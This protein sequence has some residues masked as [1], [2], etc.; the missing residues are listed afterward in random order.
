M[1]MFSIDVC[2]KCETQLSNSQKMYSNGTCCFCGNTNS[3]TVT[4]T[5]KIVYKKIRINPI[6]KFWTQQFNTIKQ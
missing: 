2:V 4:D 6:W 1:K 5:K 3:S